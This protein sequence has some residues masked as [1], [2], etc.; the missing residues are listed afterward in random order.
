M[1]VDV[2]GYSRLMGE[3]EAG[4]L[5]AVQENRDAARPIVI[6]F[7]GRLVKTMGDGLL[8]EFPS[9]VAAVK[10][11]VLIQNMMAERN[12]S[13][14]N[15]KRIVYRIGIHIG[16]V[17]IE[18][19]DIFG[20]GVNIAARLEAVAAPGGI[21]VSGSAYEHVRGRIETPFFDLGER[22]LKNIAQPVRV[23]SSKQPQSIP[24]EKTAPTSPAAPR[25]SIVVL[26]F[27]NIGGDASQDYFVDGVTET[28][29]TDLSRIRESFV[30]SRSTAFTYK[31]KAVDAKQI[32]RELNVRYVLEGSVQQGG[33]R[34]R[35]NVQLIDAENGQHLW[36]ERFDKPIAD[37]FDL[38]DEIVAHLARQLDTELIAVE[39]RRAERLSDHDSMDL[40][41]QGS[42][43]C[44]K[45][46]T[47]ENL[48]KAREFFTRALALDPNNVDALVGQAWILT[49]VG[50]NMATDDP[51]AYYANAEKLAMK[52]LSIAPNHATAHFMLG[53]AH[54]L[55]NRAQQAIADCERALSLDR[56]LASAHAVMG[57]AKNTLGH[58][59]ETEKYIVEA[60]RLSPRDILAYVWMHLAGAAK[61]F[62]G[63]DEEAI[64]WY[65]RSI[66]AN[67]NFAL[68]HFF[69]SAPLAQLGRMKE[70]QE[71]VAAGLSLNPGF[72]IKRAQHNVFS[73]DPTYL[74]QRERLYDGLRKAGVP[75]G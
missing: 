65:R 3:D 74:A 52:A 5:R 69:I 53:S 58:A 16:D 39:A 46:P 18:D 43:Y 47:P 54:A 72:T 60:L 71:S 56:N 44:N 59:E 62:L 14:A 7:G 75:A 15:D 35:V 8:L 24:Q 50:G 68:A 66:E 23:F 61:I 41:F 2:V 10:C 34:L 9:I 70:A 17:L 26:P 20:E 40:Y 49:I 11:A 48:T 45:G 31:G 33:S 36:A 1:A 42:A 19:D 13:I 51:M 38:Q 27:A 57:L 29:T 73:D 64:R 63:R 4:T 22:T 32:G 25:L 12:Q 6:E 30:I 37:F 21:C 28:L 55:A 67:R